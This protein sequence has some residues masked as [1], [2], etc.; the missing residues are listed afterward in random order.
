MWNLELDEAAATA[1][2]VNAFLAKPLKPGEEKA[3]RAIARKPVGTC[4]EIGAV[5]G[6]PPIYWDMAFG[7][8]CGARREI[9]A[10]LEPA[11]GAG[12]LKP[13][14]LLANFEHS[15]RR[16]TLKPAAVAAFQQLGY[17]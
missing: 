7:K 8:A 4:A 13:I 15:T 6:W 5:V 3:V 10:P 14:R 17:I 2:I 1:L 11:V 12:K 16:W 9:L